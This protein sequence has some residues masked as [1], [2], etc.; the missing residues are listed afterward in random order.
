MSRSARIEV[1]GAVWLTAGDDNLGGRGR[2]ALLRAVAEQGSI[3][4]AARAY[5][6][7]YKAAWDAIDA[8]N[9]L[10][11]EPLIERVSGGRGGGSTR[12]TPRGVRLVQRFAQI[13][14]VHQRFLKLL[15]AQSI[16]VAPEF[17]WLEIVNMKT[18]ARNQFLGTVSALRTGAVNDEVEL[19]L[20]GGLRL[21]AIIASASTRELG[22][23]PSCSVIGLIA[24][25]S[26]LLATDLAGA[27][28]SARNQWPGVVRTVTPGAVNA[29]VRL[30]LDGG[31]TLV[32]TVTQAS[33]EALALAPGVRATALI[34]AS[35]VIL[36]VAV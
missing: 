1:K 20:P 25:S 17:S 14:S 31:A 23:A 29:D 4:Q 36:A 33:I 28:V 30:D 34:K 27:R 13:D 22:L 26:V 2:M 5:G 19:A 12:L 11:G 21:V 6:M 35:D 32:A 24:S 9:R 7:S 16:D 3:T 15:D 18:S 10:A 8:M